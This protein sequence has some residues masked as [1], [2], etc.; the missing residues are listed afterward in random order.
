MSL[1]GDAPC[2]VT[3]F[4]LSSPQGILYTMDYIEETK[5]VFPS[6]SGTLYLS[7]LSRPALDSSWPDA[8]FAAQ[9]ISIDSRRPNRHQKCRLSLQI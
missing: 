5:A 1:D 7:I 8:A 9:N 6:P 4:E 2:L 3:D